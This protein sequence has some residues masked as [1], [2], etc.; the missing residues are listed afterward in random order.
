MTGRERETL[1]K[2]LEK[3]E[4]YQIREVARALDIGENSFSLE[5]N[6][7]RGELI[8]DL[9]EI[10]N[11]QKI[12]VNS[13]KE[14]IIKYNP[15]AFKNEKGVIN[16]PSHKASEKSFEQEIAELFVS[17]NS[18]EQKRRFEDT[19]KE[20]Q[21]QGGAFLIPFL[22]KEDKTVKNWLVYCLAK[23]VPALK[24]E[25]TYTIKMRHHLANFQT[26][27]EEAFS[28]LGNNAQAVAESLAH[29]L[30]GDE[31]IIISIDGLASVKNII[32]E[33]D[34]V[35][36]IVYEIHDFWSYLLREFISI[37]KEK[38]YYRSHLILLLTEEDRSTLLDDLH[39][40]EFIK[41]GESSETLT[42]GETLISV[43]LKTF[44]L[45]STEHA[46]AW[47]NQDCVHDFYHE[48]YEIEC[49]MHSICSGLD[50]QET[51]LEMLDYLCNKR[52]RISVT[53]IETYWKLG[54]GS[55]I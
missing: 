45:I 40:F 51:S 53:E 8:G 29:F 34:Q 20:C 25:R 41:E 21:R 18:Q 7:K 23:N 9:L 11:R 14:K 39:A 22:E 35:N 31:S 26:F 42:P 19:I 24:K 43:L 2:E 46:Q 48:D 50:H 47:L 54:S 52:F 17:L 6:K 13:I 12:P 4:N 33:V 38:P 30:S 27:W 55:K 32:K 10:L 49:D 16:L 5:S 3:L 1:F 15:Q 37:R 28:N 44:K 36:K